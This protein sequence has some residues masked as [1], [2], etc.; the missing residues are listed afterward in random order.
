MKRRIGPFLRSDRIRPTREITVEVIPIRKKH[1]SNPKNTQDIG[2]HHLLQ[3]V[4]A[5]SNH[6]Y[7]CCQP[8]QRASQSGVVCHAES[9]SV[10]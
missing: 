5:Y 4:G 8:Q 9:V 7:N 6:Q 1:S 3:R 10:W 2:G